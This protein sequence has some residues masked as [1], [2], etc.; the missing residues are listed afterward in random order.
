MCGH[1]EVASCV[2]V[3]TSHHKLIQLF[4]RAY[5]FGVCASIA[6]PR[7]ACILVCCL[8]CADAATKRTGRDWNKM[9]DADWERIEAEWE[10]PE[11]KEA[12][13]AVENQET[14]K[15]KPSLKDVKV[16]HPPSAWAGNY[17]G[18]L[19]APYKKMPPIGETDK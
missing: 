2:C 15:R 7:R 12:L 16:N 9:T 13:D 11:E 8:A 6:M 3:N 14:F 18:P 4:C 5:F 1:D 10:T 19:Y 17:Q